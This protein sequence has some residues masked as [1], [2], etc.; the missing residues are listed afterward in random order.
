M[1]DRSDDPSHHEWT[2]L[3]RSYISLLGSP[4][5]INPTTHRTMSERSYHGATSRSWVHHDGSIRRP[6]A[7]WVNALTTELHLTPGFTMKD[8]SDH[9]SHHE[10]TLLP[11]SYI[12]LLGSPWRIDPTTH[13]T[14]S[15]RSYHGATS[16]SWVHHEGSIRPPIAPWANA[17][18]TEL[19]LAPGF[20]M[21]DRS[22]DPSHHE[23]TLLP[24]SYISLLGSPWRI[25]PTTHRT[26]SEHSY[27][28]ATSRSWV[29]HDGSIRRPIA[30]WVNALTTELHLTPGFTMKDQSDH[31]SHHERTLLP[32]SYIS[33]LGSP[34]R[35][36][37]TTHRTMSERS[38]HGATSHSWV[39]HE[40]SIRPPIAPWANALTTE[41]HLAPGFTMKDQSDHPS[42]HEWTLLPRSYILLL[43]SPWRIDPTTHR[44]MSERSYHRATSRSWVHHEGSIRPPIAPWANALTTEQHLAPGFTMKD[45]SD[46]PSHHERTLLPRS[47]ILLLG[48]PWRINPTTHRT[49][50][51]RSYHGATSCSWVHHEG[52]IRPPIA[53]WANAL[54]T[55]LHL[56]PGFTMKD[57][58]DHPSHHERTLLPRSYILL[59]G[60]PWRINPTTHRTMSERSYHGA[61]SCSWVHH[62]G[63]IRPPIA[64]WANALTTELHLAPGFTMKDQ[65]DHPSH[66]ERT[67]LPRNYILLLG[68]PWRINPTTH[69]TM[70]E[71]SY[72]GAT[73]HSWVHH[74]GSIRPPIAPWANALTT[75]LHLAPG[76]TMK[77]QSDHPS[78]HER[79][80]LPRSYILLLGSPWRINPTT[81]RT[82]SERSYHGA[83]SC[84][85]VHH[86][87]SI[88]PPIAPWA[89]ALTTE[90]H[91][92]PGFTMKDQSDHPS[93]HERT[94]LPRSYISL[95]GSPW[96]INPTTHRTMS[97]RSYHGATSRSWVHHEGSIRRPITPWAN[98]L[99][100]ELHLAPGFTMKDQSDHPSYHERTLL[101]RSYI[102]L[103]GSPWRINPTTHRTMSE[104][105]YH[106]ATSH[107]HICK[108]WQIVI[109]SLLLYPYHSNQTWPS[110][111]RHRAILC[112][113]PA[114]EFSVSALS[115]HPSELSFLPRG[116]TWWCPSKWWLK[117]EEKKEMSLRKCLRIDNMLIF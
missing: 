84:S 80:L 58:S 106:G 116:K 89:N 117:N 17:L 27:H 37:P 31:P 67:L 91:L 100:T 78:H 110:E 77:D 111:F 35:I 39:H 108:R 2:L 64:P 73:S 3:P 98:A 10:R 34:W 7:P 115:P 20:T 47:Y 6:I 61:T 90:L 16:H 32:R 88:R 23:W 40:G 70:S 11:R 79:T 13:R 62:E 48:S 65:S 24:R 104:R 97:E 14:M 43:G 60:S 109:L 96:R 9:P 86:E 75:E 92:A 55:E 41:L 66:H 72:H 59:L 42:H 38:Y 114:E 68:S 113:A 29:H 76:F 112:L 33:L 74:E 25:N 12:S 51:E 103:L 101:P 107:S 36:N 30:P 1:T 95:L 19:H 26:M 81:H 63:S 4:W 69:R 94:L 82:M 28:G 57:Q 21:T 93:H 102:S 22:D 5:R 83:T 99:T 71:R 18:T 46:H 15:E 105:S 54:T 8:Q 53:P 52:S 49:M 56:A 85:W 50:S 44:T 87:G 45:Q